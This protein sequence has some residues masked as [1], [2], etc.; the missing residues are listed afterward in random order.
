MRGVL[1]LLNALILLESTKGT[2]YDDLDDHDKIIV[3]KAIE[4]ANKDYGKGKHLD[5]HTIANRNSNM[6]NVI[7]RPTSCDKKTPSVHRKKCTLQNTAPQVSC[8]DCEGTME[9]CLLLRKMDE[10][11]KRI[12]NCPPAVI[13]HAGSA[14]ALFQKSG[15]GQQQPGCVGC[16]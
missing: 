2:T 10:I 12:Q 3:D 4:Q 8:I 6:V 14:F 16:I 11:Q 1:F 5:F 7:L 15:N 13:H 9:R